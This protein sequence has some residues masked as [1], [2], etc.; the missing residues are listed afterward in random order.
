MFKVLT[1]PM[2]KLYIK[3]Y[4]Y[5]QCIFNHLNLLTTLDGLLH[6]PAFIMFIMCFKCISCAILVCNM[7]L[8]VVRI[9]SYA[10][11]FCSV[12]KCGL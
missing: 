1:T 5:L 9:K 12:F 6:L 4:T 8:Y 7:T 2:I 3:I 11:T 10:H